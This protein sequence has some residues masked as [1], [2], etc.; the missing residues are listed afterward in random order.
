MKR[1]TMAGLANRVQVRLKWIESEG[2]LDETLDEQLGGYDG[3]LVPGGFGKRGIDGHAA[4]H[5]VMPA[6]ARSP[7]SASAWAWNAA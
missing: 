3:I 7:F 4:R 2:L 5:P 6:R 1:C